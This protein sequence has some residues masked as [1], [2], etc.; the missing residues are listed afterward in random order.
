MFIDFFVHFSHFSPSPT[1][2]LK[3]D[4]CWFY[5]NIFGQSQR[6]KYASQPASKVYRT[7]K[8]YDTIHGTQQQEQ[9]Q[10]Y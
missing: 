8:L 2:R 9:Q 7:A 10:Q 6:V 3:A 5:S 1:F 4:W